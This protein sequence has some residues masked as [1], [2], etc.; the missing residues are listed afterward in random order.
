MMHATSIHVATQ[1][2]VG[3][4]LCTMQ[5]AANDLFIVRAAAHTYTQLDIYTMQV[6]TR[7]GIAQLGER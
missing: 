6:A 4:N 1:A 3:V 2:Q 5:I 7:A